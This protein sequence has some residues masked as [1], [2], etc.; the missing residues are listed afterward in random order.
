MFELCASMFGACVLL[1]T[2]DAIVFSELTSYPS[3][4]LK[5]WWNMLN[6]QKSFRW[7]AGCYFSLCWATGKTEACQAKSKR[8]KEVGDWIPGSEAAPALSEGNRV[9]R[10]VALKYLQR[11]MWDMIVLAFFRY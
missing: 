8:R 5:V 2:E 3:G 9:I 6:F 7:F 11:Y 1:D 4:F 10:N